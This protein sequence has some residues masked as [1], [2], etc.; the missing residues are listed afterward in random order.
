M[1]YKNMNIITSLFSEQ[2]QAKTP[3]IRDKNKRADSAIIAI[4]GSVI[5]LLLS[6]APLSANE[7]SGQQTLIR[8]A[9]FNVSMDA[10]NYL[11]ENE[12]G[13]GQELVQALNQDH[14]QIKNIA[15]IIQQIRP[16]ILLLNEFDY[17][18]NPSQGIEKFINDYLAK[19]QHGVE[20]INYPY[21]YY[22]PVNTGVSTEFDLDNDGKKTG[23]LGDAYGFGHFPGHFAM[24]LLSRYPI[25]NEN[26]RTFQKFLWKDMPD[27][28]RPIDPNTGES[29]YSEQEWQA[30]RL[31][32]K[33]HW[34]IPILV[35]SKRIHILASH[36]TPPVFDGDED[37]NGARNHDE[38]R[39]WNDYITLNKDSYVYDDDGVKGG[40][41]N[42]SRF[43]LLGDQNASAVEGEAL[44]QG[45]ANLLANPLTNNDIAPSSHAGAKNSDS[46]F[47]KYHTAAW[48]MRADYVLPSRA[49][50]SIEKAGIFWPEQH[51]P[52][53][54]LIETRASSSDHRLVWLDLTVNA[55]AIK[56]H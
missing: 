21:F 37:R 33:S 56:I 46:A 38:I 28:K 44:P 18:E 23:N 6:S 52:L 45:I 31:S 1:R 17:I 19:S 51:S 2:I 40:I 34:D 3:S 30:L 12:I 8:V 54:R 22:A 35:N 4:I 10:T 20:S 29:W 26:I 36:P 39:F 47:A 15:E 13:T 25:D 9:T 55:T 50:L 27:A 32:S 41:G 5:C 7:Q 24:V 53:Y 48:Q 16:D 49:G 42:N 11:P 43:I 14:P